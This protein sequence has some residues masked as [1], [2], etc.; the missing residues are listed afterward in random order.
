MPDEK[1]QD[2]FDRFRLNVDPENIDDSLQQLGEKLRNTVNTGRYTRVR[3]RYRGKQIGPDIP[4]AALLAGE[5]A[6]FWATGWFR[7]LVF[8]LGIKSFVEVELVHAAD[9]LVQEG[10]DLY[11]DGEVDAAEARYREA[12]KKKADDPSALYNL[13]VLLRVTG[14]R[15]EA[16]QCFERAAMDSKHPDGGR[17]REALEK[18]NKGPRIL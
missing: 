1:V 11:L 15:Q 17:A 14:R 18:M 6:A 13:G 4:M 2:F 9:E 16:I 10:V 7:A 5:V 3:L 8:N 12:L